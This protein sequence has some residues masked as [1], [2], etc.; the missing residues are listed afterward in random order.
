MP[1]SIPD[2]SR[3]ELGFPSAVRRHF[4]FLL[5]EGYEI[6]YEQPTRVRY[7]RGV[8]FIDV[9]H[10]RAS[11]ELGVEF[12]RKLTLDGEIVEQQ[13]PL[14]SVLELKPTQEV[15]VR[16]LTATSAPNVNRF[17]GELASL[18][19]YHALPILREVS[20]PFDKISERV[21][22]A[23]EALRDSQLAARLRGRAE[24]A[25]KRQDYEDVVLALQQLEQEGLSSLTQSEAGKL[26]YALSR[27]Q[28]DAGE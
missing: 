3:S 27:T 14:L 4:G 25:W 24:D 12:G 1:K 10:G 11:Y 6:E 22:Q 5:D 2:A 20:D 16:P 21:R 18:S 28:N 23:G 19:R 7:S 13:F 9:F 17:L 15:T 8:E 26:R